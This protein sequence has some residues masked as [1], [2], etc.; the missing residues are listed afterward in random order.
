MNSVLIKHNLYMQLLQ[1][2]RKKERVIVAFSGGLDSTFLLHAAKESLHD[3]VVAVTL[4]APYMSPTEIEEAKAAAQAMGVDHRVIEVPFPEA[5]RTNPKDRCYTCKKGL[6]SIIKEIA[7]SEQIEHVLDGTN[8]DDLDDYRPG[9]RALKELEI[10][11][12]MLQVG[13]TKQTIRDLAH[14]FNLSIWDKPA[15]ACLLSRIPHDTVIT[16]E[17]L[18]R[19][20]Q[21]E[22]TLKHLGFS[23]VRLRNHGVLARIEVPAEQILD[24]AEPTMRA[25]IDT[26]LKEY[27]YHYVTVDLAGYQKGSLNEP[28]TPTQE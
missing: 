21:A 26:Q 8:L 24:V 27:G 1:E 20:D 5:I 22:Q 16:K 25:T 17:E 13:L 19:I 2:L 18:Q 9:M 28:S 14:Q 4:V 10:E 6:F 7:A 11:S 23:A 15:A 3:D 12:P